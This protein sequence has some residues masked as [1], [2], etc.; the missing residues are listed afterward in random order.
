[1]KKKPLTTG[2]VADFCDVSDRTVLVWIEE[3]KLKTYRTPGGHNRISVKDFIAFLNEHN[4]PVPV[5]FTQED[6]QVSGAGDKDRA[7]RIL[8]VDDDE[9]IVNSLKRLLKME[10]DYEVDAAFN[11]FDAGMKVLGF[12]P[13]IVLLDIRMPGMDGY[14]VAKRIK[15]MQLDKNIRIIAMS[16]YFNEDSKKTI[17]DIGVDLCINKPFDN[18]ELI[19]QIRSLI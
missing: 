6:G 17:T 14:E 18:D 2:D 8:I 11:G 19:A 12:D 10:T 7:K 9:G 3:G 4:M 5:E 15:H 16:A 13:D 1:M